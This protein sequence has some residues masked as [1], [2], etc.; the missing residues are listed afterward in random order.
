MTKR[1]KNYYYVLVF[2]HQG[3]KYVTR[4]DHQKN[5][6][7]WDGFKPLEFG[8]LESARINAMDLSVN[9]NHAVPV[10][11]GWSIDNQPFCYDAGQFEWKWN[12]KKED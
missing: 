2:T 5:M 9:G 12:K 6:C 4:I 3:P 10:S 7:F 11:I 8:N 1:K